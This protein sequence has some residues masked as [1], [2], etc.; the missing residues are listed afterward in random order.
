MEEVETVVHEQESVK[1]E[2]EETEDQ[3]ALRALLSQ[4]DGQPIDENTVDIIETP[5][6]ETDA[7]KQDVSELPE[8][9]S[10]D[11]YT[12]IPVSQFGAAM[13][14]GMGWKEGTPASRTM[15]NGKKAM[16]EPW[17]PTARPALLG[18]GAKEREVLDD[19]SASKG[20]KGK[21]RPEK[22]Y[23]PVIKREK[24]GES[25]ALSPSPRAGSKSGSA[26]GSGKVSRRSS[27]SPSRRR[28][29]DRHRD[30]DRD[31][32]EDYREDDR[33]RRRERD[34][35][36]DGKRDSSRRRSDKSDERRDRERR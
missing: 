28:E 25:R 23:V 2:V 15:A 26:T 22:R 8:S 30:R 20:G 12:R 1:M 14:R 33:D 35:S 21:K 32:R 34:Y 18:L 4:T 17:L 7:Y 36:T 10:L 13:L 3:R 24:D 6:S 19:G 9:A 27:R 31:R 29:T 11:A 5:L 16:V